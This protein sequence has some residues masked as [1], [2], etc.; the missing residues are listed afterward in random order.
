MQYFN[1][2]I[3]LKALLAIIAKYYFPISEWVLLYQAL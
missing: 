2:Y 1:I 3:V